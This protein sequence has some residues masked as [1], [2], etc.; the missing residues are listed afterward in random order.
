MKKTVTKLLHI[1]GAFAPFR[2]VNRDKALILT[3]HRFSE[4]GADGRT[5]AQAFEEQVRYLT[6]HY[7]I[8]PLSELARYLKSRMSLPLGIASITIDDGYDDAYRIAFP[9]LKKYNASATLF[10]VS[11]FIDQ[12]AWLW[13]DK[14]RFIASRVTTEELRKAALNRSEEA[15]FERPTSAAGVAAHVNEQLKKMPDDSRDER[16]FQIAALL[17]ILIPDIPPNEC[18]GIT[19]DQAREMAGAG[20]HI[21]SHTST[22]PILTR[23]DGKRLRDELH[24]SRSRIEAMLESTVNAFC[25]P[26]GD[27]DERVCKAVRDAGYSCAVTVEDGLNETGSDVFSLKR[28]HSDNNFARFNQ[29]TSGFEQFKNRLV[30]AGRGASAT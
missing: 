27:Y 23:A 18:R 2:M 5:S 3:Y 4:S 8:T 16:I 9:I 22:H 15:K 11:S 20:V 14:L 26:N 30:Y 12:T 24:G 7:R 19:W 13:T 17:G 25:Y 29:C 1:A 28:V 21:G 10:V 6:T